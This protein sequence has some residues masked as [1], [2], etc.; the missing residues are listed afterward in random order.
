M[1]TQIDPRIKGFY[2]EESFTLI[3]RKDK[4]YEKAKK[5]ELLYFYDIP[6]FSCCLSCWHINSRKIP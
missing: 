4:N 1:K 3:F 2:M 6:C 5:H